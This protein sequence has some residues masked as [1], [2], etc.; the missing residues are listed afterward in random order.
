M[1][2]ESDA[3]RSVKVR[4]CIVLQSPK[5]LRFLTPEHFIPKHRHMRDSEHLPNEVLTIIIRQHS[6]I[7]TCFQYH[8]DYVNYYMHYRVRIRGCSLVLVNRDIYNLART[9]LS[10]RWEV[11]LNGTYIPTHTDIRNR[12]TNNIRFMVDTGASIYGG[13]YPYTARYLNRFPN[14]ERI[15]VLV[16]EKTTV[17]PNPSLYDLRHF[18]SHDDKLRSRIV[19]HGTACGGLLGA[20]RMA[21]QEGNIVQ[22]YVHQAFDFNLKKTARQF[23]IPWG[24]KETFGGKYLIVSIAF[25]QRR[26]Y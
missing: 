13:T 26:R 2:A 1:F 11:R 17:S 6:A 4:I 12:V 18:S 25:I 3:L 20:T 5:L 8:D 16:N 7:C 9:I 19:G 21:N 10:T 22:V 23:K 24:E 15:D 14:L